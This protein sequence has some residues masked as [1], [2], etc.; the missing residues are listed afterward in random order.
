M[1]Q[2]FRFFSSFLIWACGSVVFSAAA[3]FSLPRDQVEDKFGQ[4][5]VYPV[6][7]APK[8]D[9]SRLNLVFVEDNE[10]KKLTSP[11][12]V[13]FSSAEKYLK[14]VKEASEEMKD[15]KIVGVS[16]TKFLRLRREEEASQR[17]YGK[18][19]LTPII[20]PEVELL[21]AKK[22]LLAEG[23]SSKSIDQGLNVPI[24]Y[25]NPMIVVNTNIGPRQAFFT[26]LRQMNSFIESKPV[27]KSAALKRRVADINVVMKWMQE[28]PDDK[29]VV[30]PSPGYLEIS[31]SAVTDQP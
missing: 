2:R 7:L 14:S 1:V 3:A 8:D 10:N 21:E 31:P 20:T 9:Q 28:E 13:I 4:F 29:Y 18:T 19:L 24:F 16:V 15:A 17:S 27:L 23:V 22:I 6:F 25:S 5:L 26:S 12:F 11:A 30:Y